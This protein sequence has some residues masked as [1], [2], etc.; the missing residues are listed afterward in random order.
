MNGVSHLMKVYRLMIVLLCCGVVMSM[1]MPDYWMR[2]MDY[3]RKL[4]SKHAAI[5]VH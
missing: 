5:P 4:P 2:L 3:W 1:V